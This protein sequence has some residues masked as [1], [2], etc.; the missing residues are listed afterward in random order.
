VIADVTVELIA[1]DVF[2]PAVI[3]ESIDVVTV[4]FTSA[5]LLTAEETTL[6]IEV[7]ASAP[8][9]IAELTEVPT[10]NSTLAPLDKDV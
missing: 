4:W 2:A 10:V 5:P 1:V 3:A 6:V 8:L 7:P 9:E